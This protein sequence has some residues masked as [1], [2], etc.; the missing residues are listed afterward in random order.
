VQ[1]YGTGNDIRMNANP[2]NSD[3]IPQSV[4]DPLALDA[5][6][7]MAGAPEILNEQNQLSEGDIRRLIKARLH[8]YHKSLSQA[9]VIEEMEVCSGRAR[10]DLAVIGDE[11]L[12]IEIKGPKDDVTRLPLQASFYS[13]CFDRVVIVIHETLV[14]KAEPLIPSW[15][16]MVVGSCYSGRVR[17][18]FTRRPQRNPDLDLEALL[19]LLWRVEIDALLSELL[20]A[21]AK[22]RASKR[23]LRAQLLSRIAPRTL[24][25]AGLRKLRERAAWRSVPLG[26]AVQSA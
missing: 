26:P 8:R 22:P 20:G 14:P 5:A 6:P 13:R 21:V 11:L 10:V 25:G 12:G 4:A 7:A 16:G 15:W 18:R 23:T 1:L 3:H 24:H 9:L 19:S 17:Y 2:P